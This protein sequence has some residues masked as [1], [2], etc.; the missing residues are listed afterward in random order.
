MIRVRRSSPPHH[1]TRWAEKWTAKLLDAIR[2]C[3]NGNS[4]PPTDS[5]WNK[6]NKPY[7]KRALQE[8]FHDKCAYC[9]SKI[10]H[11][12]Y[13]HIEHYR[14]KRQYPHLTFCWENFLLACGVCNG[15]TY[16]GDRFPLQDEDD[17]KPLLLNPCDDDPLSHLRFEQAR[18]IPLSERGHTTRE[19][20]GL[21]RDELFERRRELLY[22]IDF[23]RR[24]VVIY[25]S[26][27]NEIMAQKGRD[28]LSMAISA[29]AEYTAMVRQFMA[30]PLPEHPPL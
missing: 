14:P 4:G 1:L 15:P 10:T 24:S 25:E 12:S 13:P 3:E 22:K 11:V 9:E 17:N 16:K 27:G 26:S 18:V 29:E 30:E 2:L 23:I 21:N 5:L 20:V 8:M 19:L 6:Y 28:L 7:V